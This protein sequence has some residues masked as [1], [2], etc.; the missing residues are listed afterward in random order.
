MLSYD[1]FV[2][3]WSSLHGGAQTAGIV[4]AWLRISHAIARVL[5]ALRISPNL[6]T[7]LGLLS[8]GLT[9]LAGRHWSAGVFLILSLLCDG[10]DG[11][12][13]IIQKKESAWGATLDAVADRISEAL[14]AVAFYRL[15]APLSW[16]LL[17]ASL[18]VF[19]EYARAKLISDGVKEIG[20]VTPAERP[21]R[22]SFL[23][24]AIIAWHVPA[25]RKDVIH[26]AQVLAALQAIS[27]AALLRF[28][29][30]RLH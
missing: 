30:A 21:V 8:A 6:L 11:S 3:R 7:L 20:L 24:V 5:T 27:F 16:V 17:L 14:W 2:L 12:V 18:A 13:A 19:Q 4:G 28:A 29:Y 22:A 25:L 1:E 26:I 15:G 10:V 9:A 23:F